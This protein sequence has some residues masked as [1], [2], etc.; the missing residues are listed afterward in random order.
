M[1]PVE[2][3][4]ACADRGERQPHALERSAAQ[5]SG[6]A[7]AFSVSARRAECSIAWLSR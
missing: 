7:S 6:Y 3:R 5:L 2:R 4:L 1:T